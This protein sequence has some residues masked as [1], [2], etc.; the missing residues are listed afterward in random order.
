[1][2][3]DKIFKHYKDGQ[4]CWALKMSVVNANLGEEIDW[5]NSFPRWQESSAIQ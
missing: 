4:Y 3:L 1:M 5:F 2:A